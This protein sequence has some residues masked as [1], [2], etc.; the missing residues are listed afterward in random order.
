[1]TERVR[2]NQALS[3]S[4]PDQPYFRIGQVAKLLGVET[5]V[6]RFWESEFPQIK[7][8]RAPSG[9]R[10]FHRSDVEILALVQHLLHGE[11]YTIA[12]ARRRLEE[13]AASQAPGRQAG[14]ENRQ[15]DT[16]APSQDKGRIIGE[17]KDIL[18]ILK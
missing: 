11:G 1:M 4:I 3:L 6:L 8:T 15:P 10:I 7:P 9:R 5:H 12:G 17:L 13:M 18:S 16:G 2:E 14:Q